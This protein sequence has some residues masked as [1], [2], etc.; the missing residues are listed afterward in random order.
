MTLQPLVSV[1]TP[2]YN[3]AAW[4]PDCLLSVANQTYKQIE[5]IVVDDGSTDET[6]SILE[7]AAGLVRWTRQEN[8]GQSAAINR[9]LG[10]ARGEIVGWLNSDD[11]FFDVMAVERAVATFEKYPHVDVVYGHAAVVNAE[12]LILQLL[13]APPFNAKLLRFTNFIVQPAAFVRRSAVGDHI[14][15]EDYDYSMDRDLWLR[16]LPSHNFKRVH[17]IIGI[18][19]HHSSRK[20]EARPDLVAADRARIIVEHGLRDELRYQWLRKM[21]NILR[22][23]VGVALLP[24][25][26]RVRLAFAGTRDPAVNLLWRQVA[27]PRHDMPPGL[28]A[29]GR[30]SSA[31]KAES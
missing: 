4:L 30:K 22:R 16:L 6:P 23:F 28:P 21:W 14:V 25:S 18:D 12:G 7:R 9:A 17:A 24:E 2:A 13:W 15:S 1:I 11:A 20:G 3:Q 31:G 8:A 27:V 10:N 26:M 19:R 29:G 5:H